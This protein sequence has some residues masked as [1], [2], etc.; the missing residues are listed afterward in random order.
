MNK[1]EQNER[2][3][4]IRCQLDAL[5]YR[6]Y[7]LLDSIDLV[8]Q[9]IVDFLH[10]TDSLKQYKNIAQNTLDVARNLETRSALYL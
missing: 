2:F 3:E 1:T 5:G 4:S 6:L 8:G 9:L 10:T 7:M